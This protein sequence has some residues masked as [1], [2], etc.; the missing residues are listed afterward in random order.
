MAW[1]PGGGRGVREG[2]AGCG[3]HSFWW[4][5]HLVGIIPFGGG[6]SMW[7]KPSLAA[8]KWRARCGCALSP[9]VYPAG[10]LRWQ[11]TCGFDFR[12]GL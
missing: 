3:G 9:G 4:G 5:P 11:F 7:C 2:G 6:H 12:H 1:S 8:S 10:K